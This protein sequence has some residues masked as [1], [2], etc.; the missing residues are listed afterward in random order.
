M[1]F[2]CIDVGSVR[3]TLRWAIAA[4]IHARLHGCAGSSWPERTSLYLYCYTICICYFAE[5]Q[6][7]LQQDSRQ[8]YNLQYVDHF[9]KS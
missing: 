9:S 7:I 1:I 5:E 4:F 3:F 8:K 6:L 2:T